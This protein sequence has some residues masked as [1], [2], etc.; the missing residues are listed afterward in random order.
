MLRLPKERRRVLIS[1]EA[2]AANG[3]NRDES[4]TMLLKFK[5]HPLTRSSAYR[6][7]PSRCYAGQGLAEHSKRKSNKIIASRYKPF[8]ESFHPARSNEERESAQRLGPTTPPSIRVVKCS[9]ILDKLISSRD[10]H[11]QHTPVLSSGH[12]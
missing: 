5:F 2:L 4:V 7:K 10:Y 9:K 8:S 12:S 1:R 11:M 6:G 3:E